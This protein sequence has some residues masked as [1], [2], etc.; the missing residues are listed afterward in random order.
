MSNN[1]NNMFKGRTSNLIKDKTVLKPTKQQ[2]NKKK[3]WGF[4]IE[5]FG[6]K[7]EFIMGSL[8]SDNETYVFWNK[9]ELKDFLINSHKLRDSY[10]FATNLGFDFLGTFG[11][12]FESLAQFKYI[13]RSSD[14]ICIKY[15]NN[16][17]NVVFLDTMNHLKLGVKNIGS[18][19]GINKLKQPDFIGRMPI[20]VYECRELEEYNIR[21]SYIS[22]KFAKFLQDAYNELGTNIKYTVASTSFNLFKNKYLKHIIEQPEKEILKIIFNAYYGGRTECFIHGFIQCSENEELS[23]YDINSLYPFVMK[24]YN[25]PFP[26]SLKYS[27]NP[28]LDLI[29]KY[30]GISYCYVS[31]PDNIK[32]PVLPYRHK[33]K[34]EFKLIFPR[35]KFYGWYSHIELKKAI[36]LGYKIIP[37]ESYY[38]TQ[39]FNPFKD[40]VSDL[41]KKRLWYK[42]QGSKMEIVTKILLNSLYGKMAQKLEQTE[43]Y[44]CF[45]KEQKEK[46]NEFFESNYKRTLKGEEVR[47]KIDSPDLN[48]IKNENGECIEQNRLY[49]I[50]DLE[51]TNYPKFINPIIPIYVTAYARLELYKLFEEAYNNGCDIYYCD[52]DSIISNHKF[53]T[54]SKLGG[55]KKEYDIDKMIL[56]KPKLYYIKCKNGEEVYKTKGLMGIKDYDSFVNIIKNKKY[57]YT[58]FTK[59]K[60]SLRRK[61]D[62][63]EK[64]EV[65][66]EIDLNDDKRIFYKQ[67]SLND[68]SDSKPVIVTEYQL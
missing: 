11:D 64:L 57:S 68:Y 23:L 18:I 40:F 39:S 54:S 58:K 16:K 4:D 49:Y 50:T 43:L 1:G 2:I 17:Q 44:F 6:D 59:F 51:T 46:I 41:Y 29:N 24:K 26:N 33:N 37:Y 19:I 63:N 62:F 22:F 25:Y 66:K 38:Y 21:D 7:N 52:T 36:E 28:D 3:I 15:E 45:S 10:I 27:D 65:N 67:F 60:E 55:L 12:S 8:V 14:F 53:D 48:I 30:M 13:I 31:V 9:E 35:G 56:V 5:T 42:Q 34:S 47:Y 61:L 20:N 32:Y